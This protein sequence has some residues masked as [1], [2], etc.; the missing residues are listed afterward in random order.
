MEVRQIK[1]FV[2]AVD[3]GS[4]TR[5]AVSLH[6]VQ[7]AVSQQIAQLEQELGSALLTRGVTGVR[8]TDTGAVLY[9]HARAIL[10]QID[11]TRAAV[12]SAEG[13]VSGSVEVG[14]PNGVAAV[15]AVPLLQAVRARLPLVHLRLLEGLSGHLDNELAN[16]RLDLSFLYGPKAPRGFEIERLIL[17][18]LCFM[19]ADP[20]ALAAYR[21]RNSIS[22]K[23]AVRWPLLLPGHTSTSRAL[24]DQACARHGLQSEVVAEVNSVTTQCGGVAAGLGSTVLTRSSAAFVRAR[25]KIVIVPISVPTIDRC[26]TLC[27]PRPAALTRPVHAVREL[28]IKTAEKLSREGKWPGAQWIGVRTMDGPGTRAGTPAEFGFR[29]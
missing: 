24:F 29:H 4:I 14:I 11:D 16:A 20:V 10:K 22:L 6:V 18:P 5:A 3:A 19:S 27:S 8:P 17:E 2:A 15:L 21:A 13:E 26:V 28:A 1:Y 25:Q 7:S 12:A 23:E 9:R